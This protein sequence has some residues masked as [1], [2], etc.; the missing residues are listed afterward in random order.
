M[1]SHFFFSFLYVALIAF[2]SLLLQILFS[3]IFPILVCFSSQT[4][5]SSKEI[6]YLGIFP[7]CLWQVLL[8]SHLG[9]LGFPLGSDCFITLPR[10][11]LL[12]RSSF[13]YLW[14]ETV[15][16]FFLCLTLNNEPHVFGHTH[17]NITL[18]IIGRWLS[19][20]HTTLDIVPVVFLKKSPLV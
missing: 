12:F 13:L 4:L 10:C 3:F 17:K 18:R 5:F 20:A 7:L 11:S 1:E 2:V 14:G 16:T 6:C 15:L 9:K 19:E 8:L